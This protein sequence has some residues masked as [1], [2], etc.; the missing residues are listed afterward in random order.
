MIQNIML[1]VPLEQLTPLELAAEAKKFP[2]EKPATFG[3][4][5]MIRCGRLGVPQRFWLTILE[6]K[7][8]PAVMFIG[9]MHEACMD[10]WGPGVLDITPEGFV[11]LKGDVTQS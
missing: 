3:Y 7:N 4:A 10:K 8:E 1:S 2:G 9:K 6:D 5:T 11:W